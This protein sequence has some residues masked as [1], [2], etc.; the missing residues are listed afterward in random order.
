MAPAAPAPPLRQ[1]VRAQGTPR[2]QDPDTDNR[3]RHAPPVPARSPLPRR[4][5]ARRRGRPVPAASWYRCGLPVAWFRAPRARAR[6]P[7]PWRQRRRGR[8]RAPRADPARSRS[9]VRR[10]PA[11]PAAFRRFPAPS[12][13]FRRIPAVREGCPAARFWPYSWTHTRRPHYRDQVAPPA[14]PALDLVPPQPSVRRRRS[15]RGIRGTPASLVPAGHLAQPASPPYARLA[16]PRPPSPVPALDLAP[17]APGSGS[18]RRCP[19]RCRRPSP[20]PDAPAVPLA[21]P[22]FRHLGRQPAR[23]GSTPPPGRI[24][25]SP[26]SRPGRPRT[27]GPQPVRTPVP[28]VCAVARL[29]SPVPRPPRPPLDHRHTARVRRLVPALAAACRT[30]PAAQALAPAQPAALAPQPKVPEPA[31]AARACRQ[32]RPPAPPPEVG[33]PAAPADRPAP[34]V[35]VVAQA[36]PG[37]SRSQPTASRY[38]RSTRAGSPEAGSTTTTSTNR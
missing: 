29:E 9:R 7:A 19:G 14:F 22:R 12:P 13:G 38:H 6:T 8:V 33:H 27:C 1:P 30:A 5:R 26:G 24:P 23:R 31:E 37:R 25:A 21:V 28:V 3:R 18:W 16:W 15:R 20:P 32:P 34:H 36:A 17:P 35:P 10:R 11:V 2:A 4:C